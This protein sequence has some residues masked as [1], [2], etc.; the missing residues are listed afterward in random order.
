MAQMDVSGID[1]SNQYPLPA[2]LLAQ[3]PALAHLQ[4]DSIGA[5]GPDDGEGEISGRSS[6]DA[7]S[8]GEYYDDEDNGGGY[9]SGPGTVYSSGNV[10]GTW[11]G[12][13]WASDYEGK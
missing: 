1:P 6:F 7:S 8:G 11:G 5:A 10:G 4:W 3:Y 12:H 2:A 9:V 13:E